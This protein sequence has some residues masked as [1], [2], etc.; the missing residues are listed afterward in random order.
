MAG[1]LLT[2]DFSRR[3]YTHEQNTYCMHTNTRTHI[4]TQTQPLPLSKSSISPFEFPCPALSWDCEHTGWQELRYI[5]CWCC[6]ATKS[7]R[8]CIVSAISVDWKDNLSAS[9]LV[10]WED[11]SQMTAGSTIQTLLSSCAVYLY[12]VYFCSCSLKHFHKS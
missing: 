7:N 1:L 5:S 8:S 9:I 4:Q 10:S 3:P 2:N 12:R 6:Y 11:S